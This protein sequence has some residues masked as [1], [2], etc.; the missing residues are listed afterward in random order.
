M[1][2]SK[3]GTEAV[4]HISSSANATFLTVDASEQITVAS[5]GGA[6]T[7]SV[8][9]GLAKAWCRYNQQTPS[10]TDSHNVSS[11]TDVSTG[12]AQTNLSSSMSDGNY[13]VTGTSGL[14][15]GADTTY[16]VIL[17]IR[18]GAPPTASNYTTQNQRAVASNSNESDAHINMTT[19]H[20]DLA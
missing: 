9:Q 10:V 15:D 16:V 8:Q 7:T 14:N 11:V 3:I 6:V 1:P 20:G 13:N 12:E 2:L 17:G 4:E 19:A 18:R 5:E